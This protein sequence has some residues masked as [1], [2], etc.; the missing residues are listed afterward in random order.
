MFS[1][2]QLRLRLNVGD[3][4]WLDEVSFAGAGRTL[5]ACND[6]SVFLALLDVAKDRLHRTFVDHGTDVG[7]LCRIAN[8]DLFDPRL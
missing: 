6:A 8:V 7:V 2:L 5:A 3:D 1:L 4:S